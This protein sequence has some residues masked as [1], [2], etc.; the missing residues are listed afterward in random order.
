VKKLRRN[1][2]T[3]QKVTNQ[4]KRRLQKR[5]IR[6]KTVTKEVNLQRNQSKRKLLK[7]IM[8]RM[9]NLK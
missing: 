6:Q 2:Q 3:R 5:M 8:S 9:N 4:R 1:Q 7:E